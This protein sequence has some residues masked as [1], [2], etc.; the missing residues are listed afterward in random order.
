M[1]NNT[2]TP[3]SRWSSSS[4]HMLASGHAF[5]SALR[6]TLCTVHLVILA[7]D[8]GVAQRC[9]RASQ[10]LASP[11]EPLPPPG[12]QAG[13]ASGVPSRLRRHWTPRTQILL[14]LAGIRRVFAP[15]I[16][17]SLWRAQNFFA[18]PSDK[19]P[20]GALD[21]P[22]MPSR[23]QSVPRAGH[24]TLRARLLPPPS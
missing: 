22:R 14:Q 15:P 17:A 11:P 18:L 12:A 2:V 23:K 16:L 5:V 1:L 6:S 7:P 19:G 13:G 24:P 3:R 20:G 21:F 10:H 8:S 9:E 4:L